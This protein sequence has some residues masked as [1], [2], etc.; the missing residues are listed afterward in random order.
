[1]LYI[2]LL[3]AVIVFVG[4]CKSRTLVTTPPMLLLLM[5]GG[6][7]LTLA[8]DAMGLPITAMVAFG[9][10]L[11]NTFVGMYLNYRNA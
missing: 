5:T 6:W 1:M 2:D 3:L 7:M 11:A 4:I 8:V 9:G 10:L